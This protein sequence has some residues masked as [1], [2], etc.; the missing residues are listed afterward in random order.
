[1]VLISIINKDTLCIDKFKAYKNSI[2]ESKYV[3]KI[4]CMRIIRYD[5]TLMLLMYDKF[6]EW[7][8]WIFVC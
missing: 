1:M 3:W 8:Y 4:A 7:K 5:H 6:N 2:Y